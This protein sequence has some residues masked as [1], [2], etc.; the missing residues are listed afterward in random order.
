[1]PRSISDLLDDLHDGNISRRR[2]LQALAAA[3]VA[4]PA[5]AVAQGGTG[6][7]PDSGRAGGRGRGGGMAQR[8]TVPL[9]PPFE[10][11]GWTTVWLDHLNYQCTDYK[12]A[13]AFY[14]TL[15]GWKIR[16]DDGKQCMLDIGDNSGGILIRGGLTAPPPAAITDAGL[17]VTRPP[18]HAV[19]DGF[20]W[21]ISPWDEGK[22]KAALEK[23]G[24]KPVADHR[25]S[26]YRAFRFKDPDGFDVAVTNGTKANR[27]KAPANAKLPAPAPFEPTHWNTLY[28]DHISFEVPDYRRSAAFY[29]ALLGWDARPGGGGQA[30]V[31][32]GDGGAVGGAIIRGN[33]AAR[34]AAAR[35][36]GGA[37][38]AAAAPPPPASSS[39]VSAAIGHI[40]FGIENWNTE[41]VHD[42]LKKRDVVYITKEGA[43]EPRPDMTGTLESFHVP[44]AMGWDLQIGNKIAPGR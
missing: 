37:A 14:A 30:T 34:A 32:I 12:T 4:V 28:L 17:G 1:M 24:L 41:R 22:V 2:M 5:L 21:G 25:G 40:S 11:T 16:S 19:F 3:A 36:R 8:D 38:A 15:M 10:P 18:I 13:A 42:E 35:G 23:R 31:Q 26:D 29:Q 20:A 43:H 27:R 6:T 33:A 7:R 39:G 9:V 44:D